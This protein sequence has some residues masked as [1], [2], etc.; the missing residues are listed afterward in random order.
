MTQREEKARLRAEI[1]ARRDALAPAQRA[2]MSAAACQQAESHIDLAP[3]MVVSGFLPI[4]SEIDIAPLMKR[5][6]DRG[7]RLCLPAVLDRQTIAFRAFDPGEALVSTGFGTSG[8][9]AEAEVLDPEILLMPLSVYDSRGN[10]IG[11][12]AGH[13]DRAI[14]RLLAKGMTPRLIGFAFSLQEVDHVPAEAHDRPL[15]AI[16]TES[17]F[18]AFA[19]NG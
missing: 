2:A 14:A 3:G 10:R 18:R 17:G 5:L 15:D 16:A 19:N 7:A 6:A 9:G 4:R 11:Y 8:P 1:L 13:Y 12:G